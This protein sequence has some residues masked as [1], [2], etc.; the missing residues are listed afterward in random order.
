MPRH[1][2]ERGA[3]RARGSPQHP[4]LF[5][6]AARSAPSPGRRPGRGRHRRRARR[7]PRRCRRRRPPRAAATAVASTIHGAATASRAALIV[8]PC[9]VSS[10]ARVRASS[11]RNADKRAQQ[12]AEVG[13][14]DLTRH[15]QRLD[16]A[17]THRVGERRLEPVEAVV[18]PAGRAVVLA[19]AGERPAQLLRTADAELGQRLGQRQPGA[20]AGGEVVDDVRPQLAQLGTSPPGPE[21]HQRDRAVRSDRRRTRTR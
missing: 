4:L 5:A 19:E 7:G 14:A 15:P 8:Q 11:R 20:D 18:E 10:S 17:V 12:P 16:D 2:P 21:P 13:A 3:G 9:R 1:Q 6:A